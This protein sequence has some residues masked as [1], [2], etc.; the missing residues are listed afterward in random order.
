MSKSQKCKIIALEGIDGSGKGMQY[1]ILCRNLEKQGYKIKTL[2]FP[3]YDGF[4]GKEIGRLLAGEGSTN[5]MELDAR[6][7]SLWFAMDRM[8]AFKEINI[9]DYDYILLNRSTLSNAVYQGARVEKSQRREFIKWIFQLEYKEIGLPEPDIYIIMD[10][11]ES[12][13]KINVSKKGHRDYVGDRADVYE[14]AEDF[15]T[16]VRQCYLD[17]AEM[18]DNAVIINCMGPDGMRS[19]EEIAGDVISYCI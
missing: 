11:D 16:V 6:S 19:A 12:Q 1:G 10:V 7:M 9:D 5:A 2:D 17:V 14:A 8:A 15:T 3:S 4:F 18:L 13:S